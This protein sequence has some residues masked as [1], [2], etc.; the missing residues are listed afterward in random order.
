MPELITGERIRT[1]GDRIVNQNAKPSPPVMIGMDVGQR[2]DPTAIVVAEAFPE[3]RPSGRTEYTYI[4][5]AM[6]RLPLGTPY[7]EVAVRVRKLVGN[8][9][10][11][12]Q[13]GGTVL[14]PRVTLVIDITGVG[15]PVCDIIR[16]ELE[17]AKLRVQITEATF[18]YG[19]TITGRPG[20]REMRVGKAG[21]V[22]RLQSIFQTR[23]LTMPSDHPEAAAMTRELVDYEIKVDP[24]GDA[25][26]GAF[27]V[28]SHDDLVTALGLAVIDDPPRRARVRTFR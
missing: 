21:L 26:F 28:G 25:K 4:V 6:E 7:P 1:I 2:V 9:L 5:R 27:R 19:D 8:I 15:R 13:P 10:A 20:H 12:T 23:R 14:P 24:E 3:K 22:S 11:R 18:T 17:D 16:A